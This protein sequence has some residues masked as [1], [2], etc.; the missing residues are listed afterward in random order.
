MVSIEAGRVFYAA[1]LFFTKLGT[2]LSDRSIDRL[3]LLRLFFPL[4]T[5]KIF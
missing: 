4:K 5:D 1:G 3:M 2:R